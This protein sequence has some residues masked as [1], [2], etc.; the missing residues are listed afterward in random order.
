MA[1]AILKKKEAGRKAKKA[2]EQISLPQDHET[3]DSFVQVASTGQP[4]R[5]LTPQRNSSDQINPSSPGTVPNGQLSSADQYE[6]FLPENSGEEEE[7]ID[8]RRSAQESNAF[9]KQRELESNKEN[10]AEIPGSQTGQKRSIYD[11][12]P[13]AERVPPIDSQDL[14]SGSHEIDISSDEGFQLQAGS[15]NALRQRRRKPA[16]KKVRVRENIDVQ[17]IDSR[18]E[19]DNDEQGAELPRTQGY[20]EYERI[21]RSAKQRMAM[22]TKPPQIRSA[23]TSAETDVLYNLI[24]VHGTSWKLLKENDKAEGKVLVARDQVA[25]KDKARNMKMD[26]LKY[27]YE[28]GDLFSMLTRY[29]ERVESSPKILSALPLASY[30]SRD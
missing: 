11:R 16:T 7:D 4:A 13:L 21:N 30:R 14:D 23:W 5:A 19:I 1:V 28:F 29:S 12:D 17:T 3:E 10:V 18:A 15:S 22:V 6:D 27:V 26:Y 9:R 2:P 25:L 20:Q 24:I 8:V